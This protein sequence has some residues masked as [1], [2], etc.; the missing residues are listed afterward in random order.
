MHEGS[1][2]K[3]RVKELKIHVINKLYKT[4]YTNSSEMKCKMLL[5][6]HNVSFSEQVELFM[7]KQ[8]TINPPP[9]KK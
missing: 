2:L 7:E 4:N 8:S 9:T 5:L 3:K 6:N 1:H